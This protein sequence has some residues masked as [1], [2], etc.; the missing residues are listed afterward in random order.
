MIKKKRGTTVPKPS[1]SIYN[2]VLELLQ[3]STASKPLKSAQNSLKTLWW[4]NV[5]VLL[6]INDVIF[7]AKS[8]QWRNNMMYSTS[9]DEYRWFF[10]CKL[11]ENQFLRLRIFSDVLQFLITKVHLVAHVLLIISDTYMTYFWWVMSKILSCE[12]KVFGVTCV[13]WL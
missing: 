8:D 13:L 1:Q 3:W 6:L 7:T 5:M 4:R 11:A 9:Y 2:N 12:V 10:P